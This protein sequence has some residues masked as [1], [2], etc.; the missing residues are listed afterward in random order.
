MN[1]NSTGNESKKST[2][3]SHEARR[4]R[5]KAAYKL[6]SSRNLSS[7]LPDLEA[8]TTLISKGRLGIYKI[9]QL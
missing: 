4:P 8:L 5:M 2:T 1:N 7:T 6:P 3:R 9:V